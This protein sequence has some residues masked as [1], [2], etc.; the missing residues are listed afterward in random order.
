MHVIMA[1]TD[2]NLMALV[3]AGSLLA[4]LV[5]PSNELES[6]YIFLYCKEVS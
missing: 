2:R 1:E 5:M 4:K 6:E 3:R